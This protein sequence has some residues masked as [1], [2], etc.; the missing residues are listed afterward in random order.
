M[1]KNSVPAL[2]K[3]RINSSLQLGTN[4]DCAKIRRKSIHQDAGIF[5]QVRKIA[6]SD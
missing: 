6:K 2:Q 3:I 4:N 1:F 5:R